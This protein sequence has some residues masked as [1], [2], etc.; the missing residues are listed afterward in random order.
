MHILGLGDPQI[1]NGDPHQLGDMISRKNA[2]Q[3]ILGRITGDTKMSLDGQEVQPQAP[4][5]TYPGT[6]I[7]APTTITTLEIIC[8]IPPSSV[9][10]FRHHLC[11]GEWTNCCTHIKKQ[12]SSCPLI[13]LKGGLI[14]G[15]HWTVWVTLYVPGRPEPWLIHVLKGHDDIANLKINSF[16]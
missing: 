5:G 16:L 6:F 2:L 10:E 1:R 11:L 9:W 13:I 14:Y 7:H 8:F 4:S 12:R 15:Q 3:K